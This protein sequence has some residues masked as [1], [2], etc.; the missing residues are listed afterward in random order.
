MLDMS[1]VIAAFVGKWLDNERHVAVIYS[2]PLR[3]W[4]LEDTMIASIR[5]S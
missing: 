4:N 3:N 1:T 2:A 5:N